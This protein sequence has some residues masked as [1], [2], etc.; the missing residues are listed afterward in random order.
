M[1]TEDYRAWIRYVLTHPRPGTDRSPL[2]W[3]N[4]GYVILGWLVWLVVWLVP[5]GDRWPDNI[6]L[7]V[8]SIATVLG[9]IS[10][11]GLPILVW[12][13]VVRQSAADRTRM[14]GAHKITITPEGLLYS[15]EHCSENISWLG[16]QRI[17][18]TEEHVYF[19]I[20][21]EAGHGVPRK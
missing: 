20:M 3:S 4:L 10:V 11:F 1:N 19:F 5:H 2:H 9:L 12:L 14:A 17:V 13:T 16:I 7:V 21:S 8:L 15:S 6:F 18:V